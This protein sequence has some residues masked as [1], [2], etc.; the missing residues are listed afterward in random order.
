MK[1]ITPFTFAVCLWACAARP[2][3]VAAQ[4]SDQLVVRDAWV[5]EAAQTDRASGGYLVIENKSGQPATLVGAQLEGVG[6]V[7]LHVAKMVDEKMSMAKVDGMTIPANGRLELKPGSYHL[8]L[9][10]LT[11]A[12]EAGAKANL[13]LRFANGVTKRVSAEVRKRTMPVSQ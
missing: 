2:G 12:L 9:F 1:G 11:K 13:T 3:T 7:E 4:S 10:R 6:V 5:R 8:M